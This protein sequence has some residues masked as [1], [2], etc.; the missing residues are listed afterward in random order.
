MR[1]VPPG[2]LAVYTLCIIPVLCAGWYDLDKSK[3]RV[4][5]GWYQMGSQE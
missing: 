2:R 4:P 3:H 1:P 5:V